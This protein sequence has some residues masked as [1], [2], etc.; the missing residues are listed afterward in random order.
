M[1]AKLELMEPACSVKDR[2]GV[3]MIL[4]AERQV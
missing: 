3:N 2:I 1:A 4:E